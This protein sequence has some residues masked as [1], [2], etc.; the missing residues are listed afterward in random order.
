MKTLLSLLFK[1]SRL[2]LLL[3]TLLT[4]STFTSQQALAFSCN[5]SS[6]DD[7]YVYQGTG[8]NK[9]TQDGSESQP[10]KSIQYALDQISANHSN[11]HDVNLHVLDAYNPILTLG[12]NGLYHDGLSSGGS[13]HIKGKI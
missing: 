10:Y 6:C 4:A 1:Q 5:T 12:I 11:G 8:K 2:L 7:V 13:I 9:T 3:L